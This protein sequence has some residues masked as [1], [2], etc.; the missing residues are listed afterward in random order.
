M[1]FANA[2]DVV[3]STNKNPKAGEIL[4]RHLNMA[5]KEIEGLETANVDVISPSE[6]NATAGYMSASGTKAMNKETE[7]GSD[8]LQVL[9][10]TY[11]ASGSS[12]YMSDADINR[13][14]APSVPKETGRKREK[15]Y[16]PLFE[17]RRKG[18]KRYTAATMTSE[19]IE[20]H[21]TT[22]IIANEMAKEGKEPKKQKKRR[23]SK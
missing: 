9:T 13:I 14:Q 11:G 1:L 10:N 21:L 2:L 8:G 17:R 23:T 20:G 19:S 6:G 3:K 7:Y 18:R 16:N 22:M 12:A 4:T 5:R 15:R